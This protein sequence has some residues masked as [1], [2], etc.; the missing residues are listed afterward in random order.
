MTS[1]K[2]RGFTLIELLVVISI[3]AVL[4]ALLLPAVQS[5]REAARR[6]QC[7][8]NLKQLGL[9]AHNY[10]DIGGRFPTTMYLHPVFGPKSGIAWNNSSF[11]VQMLPQLEQGP[12]YNAVNFSMMMGTFVGGGWR[13]N[14]MYG[15][16]DPNMTV[17]ITV[18]NAFICPSDDS[19]NIDKDNPD[20]LSGLDAAGTSY[21][22]NM[23]DNCLACGGG[24]NDRLGQVILC[25]DLN[26]PCRFPQL[27]HA[28]MT[29]EQTDNGSPAGSGIFWAWG[30][31][32]GL[33]MVSDG[34]SN[35]LMI[36]EQIRKV[37]QWNAWVGANA[38]IGS[39]AVPLNYKLPVPNVGDWTH[40]YSFRSNHPGGANFAMADGS[41]KYLKSTVNFNVYQALSTRAQGEILSSD[42]Y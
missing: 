28:R 20:D 15:A 37:T 29:D 27:G 4:I 2:L 41:V 26:L 8:N 12:L 1:Q 3:I 36:G 31:N 5:A 7:I 32:V 13:W 40:Q 23:G 21:V 22:G 17:R 10:H 9:A 25:N 24:L 14:A 33:N 11:L 35:T 38:S 18:L 30:A 34:T 42:A 16:G 39:T 6:A 19:P